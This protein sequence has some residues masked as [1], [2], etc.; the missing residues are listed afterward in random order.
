MSKRTTSAPAPIVDTLSIAA[1]KAGLA[2]EALQAV[3]AWLVQQLMA[4]Q[5]AKLNEGGHA[6]KQIPLRKVFVDL[7]ADTQPETNFLEKFLSVEPISLREL[8]LVSEKSSRHLAIISID[9]EPD[10]SAKLEP[11][12][13][14]L[15]VGGPGQGKS[16][17]GQLACQLHR[18]S[19][20]LPGADKLNLAQQEVLQSFSDVSDV[21]ALKIPI[22]PFFPLHIVLPDLATW[23]SKRE[24]SAESEI[25]NE[26]K[27]ETANKL[28]ILAFMQ[29]LPS[30][31]AA[32]MQAEYFLALAA[33][34][35]TLL[36]FDG[37]DEVGAGQDRQRL[38]I[39]IRQLLAVLAQRNAK[40]LV[41][42]TTRPQGY[43]DE[44]SQIG[45][46]LKTIRLALLN[47][48][49]AMAYAS[50]LV[51][52]QFSDLEKQE[53]AL[54]RLTEAAQE[55]ATKRLLSTPLQVTILTAL[56]EQIGRVPKERWK[57]FS[58]YYDHTFDREVSRSSYASNLLRDHRGHIEQI[59]A[60]V[61][62]LLQ[63][64][65]EREGGA[66]YMSREQLDKV[67]DT[68]LMENGFE[69]KERLELGRELATAAEMR[70]VFLVEP[71]PG[72]FGFEIRSLQEFWA[73]WA[74]TNGRDSEIEARLQQIAAAPMFRNVALFMASKFFSDASH[75][76]DYFV[77]DVCEKL[78]SDEAG[79]IHGILQSGALLALEA[80]EEGSAIG[81]PKYA[82]ALMERACGLLKLPASENLRRL[83]RIANKETEAVLQAALELHLSQNQISSAAVIALIMASNLKKDWAGKLGE[84]YWPA[85][86]LQIADILE[87]SIDIAIEMPEWLS[88][89]I[90]QSSD[91]IL[92]MHFWHLNAK[93]K[94]NYKIW[95]EWFCRSYYVLQNSF[96]FNDGIF[97][98]PKE[99]I[100][101][102][103]I[104]KDRFDLLPKNW[105]IFFHV[106]E[107]NFN[108]NA[109]SLAA[110]L[111]F[112]AEKLDEQK[113]YKLPS[114]L[115]L[116]PLA[117]CCNYFAGDTQ[118]M[119]RFAADL[120]DKKFGD[121]EDWRAAE[122]LGS[123]SWS[124]MI[125]FWQVDSPWS[126]QTLFT[127]I[128]FF[129][130]G[131][132]KFIKNFNINEIQEFIKS[133]EKLIKQSP[134]K[135]I[136]RS[137]AVLTIILLTKSSKTN[138]SIKLDLM[139]FLPYYPNAI[140]LLIPKPENMQF[141]DWQILLNE[142]PIIDG[143]QTPN[144][145]HSIFDALQDLPTHPQV[146]NYCLVRMKC[147]DRRVR[148]NEDELSSLKE[149]LLPMQVDA[150]LQAKWAIIET[151]LG[152]LPQ[153]K[154]H[155]L[156]N[157]VLALDAA[158]NKEIEP[159][160][161]S[162][163]LTALEVNR[164]PTNRKTAL[165]LQ[166][167]ALLD[168]T[169]I[170]AQRAILEQL[171]HIAQN[172][173]SLLER[174]AVWHRLALRPQAKNNFVAN[175]EKLIAFKSLELK[176]IRRFDDIKLEFAPPAVGEGQWIVFLGENG[177]G[178]TTLLRSF[179][180]NL[181]NID[182][183]PIWPGA[184]YIGWP[185]TSE[186][187][188]TKKSEIKTTFADGQVHKTEIASNG[189]TK[190]AQD[191]PQT[192]HSM[193]LL[194]AYGCR[195]GSATG[196]SDKE[197]DFGKDKGPEIATLF[198][199]FSGLIHAESWLK[200][201]DAK[202]ARDPA[203]QALLDAVLHAI[204]Q[205][206]DVETVEFTDGNLLI[207][208]LG[209]PKLKLEQLSDGYLTTAG[210]FIDLLAR[211]LH[212]A[213]AAG[214]V[215][216]V[217]FMQKQMRGLVLI[218]EIDMHLHPRWQIEI[219][220]RT[221]KMMPQMSFIV[222]THNPLTLVGAKA[223]EIWIL[224][225]DGGKIR[226]E[227]G[228]DAPMLLTGGQIYT[229]YFGIRDIY[230]NGLGSALQRY[231]FLGRYALRNDAEEEQLQHLCTQ[232]DEAGILPEWEITPRKLPDIA[233]PKRKAS[234]KIAKTEA[235]K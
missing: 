22:R 168:E 71:E 6:D 172:T 145:D 62:L 63:V 7:P 49:Q 144:F 60:R 11:W 190:F 75:L 4:N 1:N 31:K 232:L 200:S 228:I 220:S 110:V 149:K 205:F 84:K 125:D 124:A 140:I 164:L 36:V 114:R 42:A 235:K 166:T 143:T 126:Q 99:S 64:E 45:I 198:E 195:R 58:K 188:I 175:L 147:G 210:W 92:P 21:D 28:S 108:P 165:L 67:I 90:L 176:D 230:P 226:A 43:A 197:N 118:K 117:V 234:S 131:W 102:T 55:E 89:K 3:R 225:N 207:G 112:F 194:F 25:E 119:R 174:P 159:F 97:L 128:N 73:A 94:N 173:K 100:D 163:F 213:E 209:K 120:L 231:N 155:M 191:P 61:A 169:Q 186:D 121:I 44:L 12:Q 29:Q 96:H 10:L 41:L 206:L 46:P 229:R 160:H 82:R 66:A 142:Y 40:P 123:Q 208:E 133:V 57:L 157:A 30:A 52:L 179:A 74:L 38:V 233:K 201:L 39:A 78:D 59:H 219:I 91:N 101:L 2:P 15:L 180:L 139:K 167:Y 132:N 81:Q 137:M 223:E 178:K 148:L 68:V 214:K 86:E 135:S 162:A 196:K 192:E 87:K 113:Y 154:D 212:I 185:R 156:P 95:P 70:L 122:K 211:W 9:S 158:L 203:K 227:P 56:L 98:L 107:F 153:E 161:L 93:N 152:I 146:I 69:E 79:G 65:A 16:T 76:R 177:V 187:G 53:D 48:K 47:Q 127:G 129:A 51:G 27:D 193:C 204:R 202:A 109:A 221:R 24:K 134:A 88:E 77:Q 33:E 215:I 26:A 54:T 103:A 217:N 182:D 20:I 138:I 37:F 14:V 104:K 72:N 111:N 106:I 130:A 8:S 17:L 115:F 218:D 13:A 151:W 189:S 105:H 34:M 224:E 50:K 19:L 184:A 5:F 136:T 199:E 18:A 171:Q 80:L 183:R 181:R 35:H 150:T 216:D 85:L 170:E 83:I 222:T 32:G 23:L 116:W 141:D